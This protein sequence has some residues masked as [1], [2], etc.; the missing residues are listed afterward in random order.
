MT[1]V[2]LDGYAL[3][4]GDLSWE[5]LEALGELTVY[6]RTPCGKT[7]ERSRGAGILLTNK[8]VLDGAVI[9]ALP[10]VKYIGVLATGYNVVDVDAARGRGIVVTNVPAY[11]AP[12]VAQAAFALLLELTN[13]AGHHDATVHQGRW[14]DSPDFC[15]WDYPLVELSGLTMGIIGFGSIGGAVAKIAQ[16]F[17]MKV[18]CNT[19]PP[20]RAGGV[21][22]V[23][24]E[25]LFRESDVVS[26]HCPLT[27]DT[28]RLVNASRLALMKRTAFVINTGR[29]GLVDER[30]LADALNDGRIASAAVDVLSTE[31]PKCDNPLLTAK[32]C[33]ITPHIAW[34]TRASRSRLMKTAV[35]NVKAFLAGTPVNV[36]S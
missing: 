11:A 7:V 6:D 3:N 12:S 4:P 31:P 29:G 13:R 34:A 21:K 33:I 1:I 35:E 18:L 36:V 28:E 10:D 23:D 16:V 17:G 32:N 22:F 2:V 5:R 24:L 30:A 8:T 14:T 26:L 20:Q 19:Y 25:T 9:D 27:D 15:Y